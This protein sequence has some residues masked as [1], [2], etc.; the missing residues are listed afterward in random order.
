MRAALERERRKLDSLIRM[1]GEHLTP[2]PRLSDAVTDE[3]LINA[4]AQYLDLEPLEKLALLEQ[5]GA[6]ARCRSL[7]ELVEMKLITAR[8]PYGRAAT[9]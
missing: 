1:A 7:I 8:T 6:L 4:L 3:E 5:A 9:H 2:E